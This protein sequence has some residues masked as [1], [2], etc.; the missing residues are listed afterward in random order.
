M[1]IQIFLTIGLLGVLF[2][3][4][5]QTVVPRTFTVAFATLIVVGIYFVW[6][7][8]DTTIIAQWLGVARGTDLLVY[9]WILISAFVGVNLHFKIRSAREE[10][11]E[12]TRALALATVRKPNGSEETE[13]SGAP[14]RSSDPGHTDSATPPIGRESGPSEGNPG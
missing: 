8:D 12:L 2:Y 4:L 11:T 9:F 7:P 5:V 3:A 13:D 10:I 1:P 6:M 14:P